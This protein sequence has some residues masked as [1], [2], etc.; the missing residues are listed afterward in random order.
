M[1]ELSIDYFNRDHLLQ[2]IKIR[3]AMGAR[4]RMCERV[5]QLAKPNGDTSILDVGTTPDMKLPY[6]NFFE[7]W[8]PHTSR[9]VACSIEDCSNLETLFAGLRFTRLEGRRL[10]FPDRQFD[11]ALCFAVLE[12]V[13]ARENQGLLLSELARVAHQFVVYTPYRYFPV[14]MHTFWPLVH[15]LPPKWHRA[16]WRTCGQP[17]WADEANLNLLSL[18][19]LQAILPKNGTASVRLLKTLGWPSNIEIHWS[20]NPGLIQGEP[21]VSEALRAP[22]ARSCG[23]E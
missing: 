4:R 8:Y 10:P 22:Q 13:G 2:P 19:S 21:C 20:A 6:N 16:V 12:H 9:L 23:T 3:L 1:G 14:E 18:R 17:F 5:I 7:R 15:W 11:V